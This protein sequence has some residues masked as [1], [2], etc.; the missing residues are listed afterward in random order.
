MNN[1]LKDR[2]RMARHAQKIARD[3]LNSAS[4]EG[5]P[6][7]LMAASMIRIG[8]DYLVEKDPAQA[9]AVIELATQQRLLLEESDS[10][11]VH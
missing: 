9:A 5:L 2:G 10:Q 1:N 7:R 11:A 6:R 8:L 3:M 4:E